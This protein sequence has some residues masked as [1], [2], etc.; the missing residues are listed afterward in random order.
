MSQAIAWALVFAIGGLLAL[1]GAIATFWG[2]KIKPQGGASN[3]LRLTL[4]PTIG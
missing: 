3:S 1:R 4:Y 2:Q